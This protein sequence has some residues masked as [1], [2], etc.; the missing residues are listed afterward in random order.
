MQTKHIALIFIVIFIFIIGSYIKKTPLTPQTINEQVTEAQKLESAIQNG[1]PIYCVL[2][3]GAEKM[4]YW[5]K[6]KLF[7]MK[8]T[9]PIKDEETDKTTIINSQAISDQNYIYSWNDQSKQ[10][11]KIKIPTEQEIKEKTEEFK[12]Y[13]DLA[14]QFINESGYQTLKNEG[15]T[16][17]CKETSLSDEEFTPPANIKF[18]DPLEMINAVQ[19]K[20]GELDLGKLQDLT[21]QYQQV[22]P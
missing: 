6:G 8:K 19:G 1:E 12:E 7:K 10:G 13:E 21:K 22:I 18:I 16:I 5:I 20:N 14:P 9:T 3:K 15:Y 4:E 17:N 2:D 11:Y